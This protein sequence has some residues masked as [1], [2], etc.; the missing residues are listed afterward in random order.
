VTLVGSVT[1]VSDCYD[2]V[3]TKADVTGDSFVYNFPSQS[4]RVAVEFPHLD[5]GIARWGVVPAAQDAPASAPLPG[6]A[7]VSIRRPLSQLATIT[8]TG[9]IVLTMPSTSYVK[10]ILVERGGSFVA[11]LALGVSTTAATLNVE[12]GDILWLRV[13]A[14]TG[15]VPSSAAG[16]VFKVTWEPVLTLPKLYDTGT[17]QAA[18]TLQ[19]LGFCGLTP[20]QDYVFYGTL[21]VDT[22]SEHPLNPASLV[23]VQGASGPESLVIRNRGSGMQTPESAWPWYAGGAL[24]SP[25]L[26]RFYAVNPNLDAHG[27]MDVW[28]DSDGTFPS[29]LKIDEF[30][31]LLSDGSSY[32]KTAEVGDTPRNSVQIASTLTG[33]YMPGVYA[34][35]DGELRSIK[36]LSPTVASDSKTFVR[37]GTDQGLSY[38]IQAS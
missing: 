1:P 37:Q 19:A 21:P 14:S 38:T 2:P 3:C 31:A 33:V 17:L 28:L 34:A 8:G 15:R 20:Y 25:V 18:G 24:S 11:T 7:Q 27:E 35:S 32:R 5:R 12:N 30:R 36:S 10:D 29:S 23:T 22:V 6:Q 4:L 13:E 26:F 16:K 9:Q